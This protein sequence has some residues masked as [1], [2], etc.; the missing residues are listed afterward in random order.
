M[1]DDGVNTFACELAWVI[2]VRA[3]TTAWRCRSHCRNCCRRSSG[4]AVTM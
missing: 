3:G 2:Y 1:L 4:V